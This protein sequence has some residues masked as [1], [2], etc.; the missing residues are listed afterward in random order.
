VIERQVRQLGRLVDDLLDVTRIVRGRIELHNQ[1]LDLCDIVRNA[2]ETTD[3]AIEERRHYLS[4][5][6]PKG[7]WVFADEARLVQIIANLLANAAKYTEPGGRILVS[8]ER[9]DGHVVLRVRDNGVGIAS[10]M[11][12][13][14]FDMFVQESQGI[15]R[16]RGGLGLGL[17]IVRNLVNMHHGEVTAFSEGPG[18]GS[19]FVVRLPALDQD[20]AAAIEKCEAE[21]AP[22]DGRP[23]LVVD[24][25]R[26]ALDLLADGLERRGIATIRA[27]DGPSA[28]AIATTLHPRIA[29]LDIGLPVMDGYELARRLHE[30]DR[31]MQLV[32]VTGYSQPGDV[33]RTKQ[34]GF[35]MHMVKPV[36]LDQI[37]TTVERLSVT[38]PSSA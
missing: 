29:L 19:E 26:D 5:N 38:S 31:S 35:V 3:A 11:L 1:A 30:L 32:A 13:H 20:V 16:M 25:N 12:P 17:A 33:E 10:D 22:D 2:L 23:V 7:L 24:D 18:K 8:A 4:V 34:A 21:R 36:S 15:D 27:Y 14:V 6:V 37:Q 28:L 9:E